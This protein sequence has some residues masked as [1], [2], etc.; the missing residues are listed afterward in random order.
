M[1]NLSYETCL[2]FTIYEKGTTCKAFSFLFVPT[3]F[4]PGYNN[5]TQ[6]FSLFSNQFTVS[7]HLMLNISHEKIIGKKFF[8]KNVSYANQLKKKKDLQEIEAFGK[9]KTFQFVGNST[10]KNSELCKLVK[11]KFTKDRQHTARDRQHT[12]RFTQIICN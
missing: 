7:K 4:D 8:P 6:H 3:N 2:F 5:R 11:I 10:P 12:A 9:K 1:F